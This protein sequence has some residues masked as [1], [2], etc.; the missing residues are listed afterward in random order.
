VSEQ[1]AVQEN[2]GKFEKLQLTSGKSTEKLV[3]LRWNHGIW[4]NIQ[5]DRSL[6]QLDTQC[7]T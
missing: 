5:L 1:T 3:N 7:V 2:C 6:T 4:L